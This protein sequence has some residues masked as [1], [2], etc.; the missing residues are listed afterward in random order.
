MDESIHDQT[1]A[2]VIDASARDMGPGADQRDVR[3]H[4][5]PAPSAGTGALDRSHHQPNHVAHGDGGLVAVIERVAMDPT[6]PLDRLERLLVMKEKLDAQEARRAFDRAMADAKAE[7]PVI[8]KNRRVRYDSK[9]GKSS[10]DYRHEDLAG[11][12]EVIDPILGRHGLSYRYRT[13]QGEGGRITVTC[14]ISHRDGYSE[15]TSLSGSPDQSGQKNNFQA[16]GSAVTYLQ[17]YTLK[18]ALGLASAH[19]D[20]AKAAGPE[21]AAP[22][23]ISPDQFNALFNLTEVIRETGYDVLPVLLEAERIEHLDDLPAARFA[24]VNRKL[25]ETA[26][27]RGAK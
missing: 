9:D 22:A 2:E 13:E 7:I 20:D 8:V 12:A 16:V 10:T 4:S 15:E 24:E 19:D 3:Q 27:K 18:A 5:V 14:I 23:V 11:I 21:T 17:R 6:V 26:A 25:K 1:E